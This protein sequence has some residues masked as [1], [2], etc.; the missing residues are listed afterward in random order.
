M[1]LDY[2]PLHFFPL[3]ALSK[4]L[5]AILLG[6]GVLLLIIVLR[7]LS[8]ARERNRH[9]AQLAGLTWKRNQFCRG[10]LI[11]GDTGSGS[12]HFSALRNRARPLPVRWLLALRSVPRRRIRRTQA[13]DG[14]NEKINAQTCATIS[15][16]ACTRKKSKNNFCPENIE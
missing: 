11:T 3:S 10:W 8:G 16:A 14:N 1:K 4:P 2:V 9:V 6:Y 5:R 15:L 7:L 13:A 12:L